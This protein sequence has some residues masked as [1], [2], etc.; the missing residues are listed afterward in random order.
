MLGFQN[1]AVGC[2]SGV[3]LS[4]KEKYGRFTEL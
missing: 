2:I 1:V 3:A 4:Y